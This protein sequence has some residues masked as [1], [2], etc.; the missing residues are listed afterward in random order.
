MKYLNNRMNILAFLFLENERWKYI[1]IKKDL[2]SKGRNKP[3]IFV[4]DIWLCNR[5]LVSNEILK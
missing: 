4:S 5:F 1:N 2:K 3:Y